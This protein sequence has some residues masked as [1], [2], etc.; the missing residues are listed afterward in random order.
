V[1]TYRLVPLD[2]DGLPVEHP[3]LHVTD[4]DDIAVVIRIREPLPVSAFVSEARR[5]SELYGDTR[6]ILVVSE[7]V[8][9][10]KMEVQTDDRRD[11]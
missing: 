8:E 4:L 7:H 10:L 5:L 11:I 9:F 1:T 2:Q 6:R 3:A